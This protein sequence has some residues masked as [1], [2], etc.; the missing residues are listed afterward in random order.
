M[1]DAIQADVFMNITTRRAVFQLSGNYRAHLF[2]GMPFLLFLFL[3]VCNTMSLRAQLVTVK[4]N[5]ADWM[6]V[7]P[8]LSAEFTLS[9]RLTLDLSA[10]GSPFKIK[11][12]LYF[13]HLRLQPELRYWLTSPLTEHYVGIT[14]FYSTYDA[15]YKKQGYFGDSYAAG[16]TY[17]YSWIL[18]RRWN[19]ELSA[20]LGVIHYRMA[21]YT[22]G[23]A[24]PVPGETG[25][26][27][28]PVKLGITFAYVLK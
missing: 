24:H 27:I 16:L 21:R 7:S 6:T 3:L 12:D 20:G 8:N 19:F 26:K 28:A 9:S 23:E 11:D 17:G 4:T 1:A 25:W 18:S 13:R 10:T 5:V 2:P 22:P 14:A 15:G